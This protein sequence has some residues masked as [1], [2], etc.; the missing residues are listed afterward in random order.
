MGQYSSFVCMSK[1][2][3]HWENIQTPFPY[4]DGGLTPDGTISSDC[5]STGKLFVCGNSS[6]VVSTADGQTWE[7]FVDFSP[8]GVNL[9]AGV[10]LSNVGL[11]SV[12]VS[13]WWNEGQIYYSS[14]LKEWKKQSDNFS[15]MFTIEE[16]FD[17]FWSVETDEDDADYY[18]EVSQYINLFNKQSMTQGVTWNETSTIP[19]G[20]LDDTAFFSTLHY[21]D[22]KGCTY[23]VLG[24]TNQF[25]SAFYA[26]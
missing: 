5:N 15:P 22:K 9:V 2:L 3:I 1:D 21:C 24:I 7:T 19:F 12:A 25:V 17:V 14:D 20:V 11:A 4:T 10:S 23:P 8:F 6:L 13:S 18:Y 26:L 16:A